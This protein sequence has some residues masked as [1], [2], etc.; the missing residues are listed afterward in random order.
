VNVTELPYVEGFR[1]DP[2]EVK[3]GARF[4]VCVSVEEVLPL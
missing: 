4:T 1:L 2:S 3:E